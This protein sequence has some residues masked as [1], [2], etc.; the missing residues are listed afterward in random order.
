VNYD[1]HSFHFVNQKYIRTLLSNKK[2]NAKKLKQRLLYN[3]TKACS[4]I[5][6][7]TCSL[8]DRSI[9]I[10]RVLFNLLNVHSIWC[11]WTP[12]HVSVKPISE[13][14][15]RNGNQILPSGQ[16]RQKQSERVRFR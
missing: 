3:T 13:T 1:D 7:L 8:S 6:G 11:W 14:S 4:G 16:N 9:Y 15:R 2:T 12:S 5:S 10:S